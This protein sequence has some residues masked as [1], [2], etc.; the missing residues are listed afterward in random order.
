MPLNLRSATPADGPALAAIYHS[1]FHDNP[2]ATTC[3]P[4]SSQAC[5][6]FLATSFVEEMSNPRFEWLVVTD[7]DFE[8]DP[9]L[10]IACAKWVCPAND[11]EDNVES[12]P[13]IEAWPKE[14][15]PEF[16]NLFFGSIGR[17]HAEIMG[18]VRHYYLELI[19]CRREHQGKGAAT[20]ML[21]WGCERADEEGMLAFLEA[22]PSAKPIYEKY[23]FQTVDCLEFTAPNGAGVAQFFML[24]E[25]KA[26]EDFKQVLAKLEMSK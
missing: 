10:P 7:P 25:G 22:M 8:G 21:K 14:G 4:Q 18:G 9:D 6:E 17:K 15:N 20:P 26:A 2:V 1:A 19:I 24:R 5:R 12:P 11:E 16:A 3:F 23:G 13:P